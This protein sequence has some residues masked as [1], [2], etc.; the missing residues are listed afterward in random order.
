MGLRPSDLRRWRRIRAIQIPQVTMTRAQTT[1]RTIPTVAP[2]TAS[3]RGSGSKH[4]TI[5]YTNKIVY[6]KTLIVSEL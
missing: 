1:A 5:Y 3:G 6:I 2:I 4:Y